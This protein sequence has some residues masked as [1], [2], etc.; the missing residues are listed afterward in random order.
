MTMSFTLDLSG[1]GRY[2]PMGQSCE[3]KDIREFCVKWP[4]LAGAGT[5]SK[6]GLRM[7]YIRTG[8][9]PEVVELWKDIYPEAYGSTHQF[10]FDQKCYRA[11]EVHYYKFINDGER[12]ETDFDEWVLSD[13]SKALWRT[14]ESLN[15][16]QVL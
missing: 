4:K 14:L 5:F 15:V 3:L 13:R 11:C 9:I 7:R 2:K 16:H 6:K 12:F 10:V 1:Y 8:D